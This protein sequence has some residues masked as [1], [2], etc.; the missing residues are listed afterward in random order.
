MGAF[1]VGCFG[2]LPIYA[3]FIRY[4]ASGPEI[5]EMDQWFQEGIHSAKDWWG[6]VP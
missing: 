6:P 5:Q 1:E 2:K 4:N 3:D